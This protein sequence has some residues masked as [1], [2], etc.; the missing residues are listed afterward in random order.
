M[1]NL[2]IIV[3]G[4]VQGVGFRWFVLDCALRH[5][6]KGY[7]RNQADGSVK[8]IAAGAEQDI[9]LFT[10]E[11]EQGNRHCRVTNIEITE[12]TQNHEYEDFFIA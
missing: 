5:R 8:I 10:K 7:V 12:L 4:R 6:I 11:V 2:E 3:S 9:S 1:P